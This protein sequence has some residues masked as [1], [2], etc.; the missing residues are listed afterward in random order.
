MKARGRPVK[1]QPKKRKATQPA[2]PYV[3]GVDGGGTKTRAVV[4]D[5]RGE[6]LGKAKAGPSNPLR[7]GVDDSVKASRQ[8]AEGACLDAGIRQ[9]ELSA[10]EVGLA[11][12]KR[13]DIRER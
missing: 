7:V 1:F 11:G 13:E 9:Q 2:P 10:A 8:A 3:L 5:S 6:V 12:V 4:A